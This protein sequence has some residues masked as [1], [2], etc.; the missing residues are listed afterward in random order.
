MS[1]RATRKGTA[2]PQPTEAELSVL[3]A[4]L[5][6]DEAFA[7]IKDVID[8]QMFVRENHR[9]IFRAMANVHRQGGVID[10]TSIADELK[11]RGELE[12]AGGLPKLA[13]LLDAVP[14]AT[15]L[16]PHARIL[17]DRAH[18]QRIKEAAAHLD[19]SAS[20]PDADLSE[21]VAGARE[22]L[23]AL[24]NGAGSRRRLVLR[25]LLQGQP[26]APPELLVDDFLLAAD[27]NFLGGDGD[28][29]KSTALLATAVA[30]VLGRPVFGSLEVR[31]AGSV[32]IGAPEDGAAVVRHHVDALTAG[33]SDALTKSERAALERDLHIIGDDRPINLLTDTAELAELL[34]DIR[35]TLLIL[36]PISD[37]IGGEDE[38]E[39]RVAQA[40]CSNLRHHIARP[41]GTAVALAGHLRKPGRDGG[42]GP[43]VHDLKGSAGWA[44][45]SRLV[46]LVSK[47][48]GGSTIT[49]RLAKSN[50]LQSGTEH[51]VTL[52]VNADPENAAHWRS[53]SLTDANLGANSQS[54]TP[55]IGRVINDNERKALSALDDRN[56]PGIRLSFTA[57]CDQAGISKNTFK[58]VRSRLLDAELAQAIPTGKK[59]PNG[60][61]QYAYAIT[62]G[63]RKALETGWKS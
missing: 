4:L 30:T 57:W 50:R 22:R 62:D 61:P 44:N 31:R 35:P 49:F 10:P 37:L 26:P 23:L 11:L 53:C 36:D 16:E 18:R 32:A 24:R 2:G 12:E 39:E 58:D 47:P 51:Q 46:W 34:A 42:G 55:G 40:V 33:L 13:E 56:E 7:R 9:R 20:D 52:E 6:E 29:G 27:I 54:F 5:I 8:E 48:K 1:S 21:V 41:L 15:Q 63:G 43:T 45:H 59:A 25:Q 14:T 17:A 60:G 38:N 28:A 19:A 3:G